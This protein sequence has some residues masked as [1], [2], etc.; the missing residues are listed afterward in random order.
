MADD[1]G[2]PRTDELCMLQSILARL[3]AHQRV[4]PQA[5]EQALEAGFGA[6]VVLEAE[7]SRA[8]V[9]ARSGEHRD[10]DAVISELK[11]RIEALRDAL[12][13]L[14]TQAVPPGQAR[15]G[16]GFVLPDSHSQARAHRN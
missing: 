2:Y 9:R 6:L 1:L 12:T 14:R 3:R 10:G 15:I 16:Y 5:I 13:D 7:L 4:D 8:Q 11:T